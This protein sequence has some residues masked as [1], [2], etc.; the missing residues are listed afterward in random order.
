MVAYTSVNHMGYVVLATAAAAARLMRER[1]SWRWTEPFWQMV[2]HGSVTGALFLLVVLCRTARARGDEPFGG[3][4]RVVPGLG[5]HSF[6]R[7]RV[8]GL[9]VSHTSCRVQIFLALQHMPWA[10]AVGWWVS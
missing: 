10:A 3:L 8:A 4:L 9:P 5:W 7:I 6:S 2:S 1:A